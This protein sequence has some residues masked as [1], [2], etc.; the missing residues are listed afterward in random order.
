MFVG[1]AVAAARID[2]DRRR[3]AVGIELEQVDPG[4]GGARK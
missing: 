1:G 2:V 4:G 3:R